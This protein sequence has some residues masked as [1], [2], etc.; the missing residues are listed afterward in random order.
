MAGVLMGGTKIDGS[1][2]EFIRVD[3]EFPH[4]QYDS[5]TESNDVMIVKLSS[6][7]SAP[8]QQVNFDPNV[9]PVGSTVTAIGYGDQQL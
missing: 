6:P 5:V 7:S 9:P 1:E 8:L 2:S 4:E 3:F